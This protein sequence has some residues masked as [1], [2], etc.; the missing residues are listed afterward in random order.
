M[1]LRFWAIYLIPYPPHDI[2]TNFRGLVHAVC[3]RL[4]Y[5]KHSGSRSHCTRIRLTSSPPLCLSY[6]RCLWR[7]FVPKQSKPLCPFRVLQRQSRR[8]ILMLVVELQ[9][10]P[11]FPINSIW[12]PRR[13]SDTTPRGLCVWLTKTSSIRVNLIF[14]KY[15]VVSVYYRYF[16]LLRVQVSE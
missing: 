7:C 5:S 8:W 14:A 2:E 10:P 9:R 15:N 1:D 6:C 11:F 4:Y 3:T 16:S 12:W 13:W